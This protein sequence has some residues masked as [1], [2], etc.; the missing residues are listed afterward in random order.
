M[1]G[2]YMIINKMNHKIYIG[3]SFDIK[4]R[5]KQHKQDLL[6]NT[7]HNYFLQKDFNNYGK[8]VFK[9][10]ILQ[11]LYDIET[12]EDKFFTKQSLLLMLENSYIKKYQNEGYSLYNI[13]DTL[14]D[15][16]NGKRDFNIANQFSIGNLCR[17]YATYEY[18]FDVQNNA[19]K[20]VERNSLFNLIT[21]NC[22]LTSK[23]RLAEIQEHIINQLKRDDLFK[24]Y[25]NNSFKYSYCRD[26]GIETTIST[27]ELNEKGQK[28]ILDAYDF[29]SFRKCKQSTLPPEDKNTLE[30][31]KKILIENNI[32]NGKQAYADMKNILIK[33]KFI[34]NNI[35][36]GY[37]IPLDYA[38]NNEYIYVK[39]YSKKYDRYSFYI[40]KKG[41]DF[42]INKYKPQTQR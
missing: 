7:H 9:Y 20:L 40:T 42:L 15:L 32:V 14:Q 22:S 10:R 38:I 24:I 12:K 3:E 41:V 37:S 21:H 33:E 1:I 35:N 6:N 30:K 17:I 18:V 13:E 19:F 36:N 28:Y 39:K 34:T 11:E 31:L 5:L 23:Q 4:Q 25:I 26:N 16:L 2:V 27:Y 29:E 8:N